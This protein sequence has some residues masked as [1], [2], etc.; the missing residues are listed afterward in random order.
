MNRRGVVA[1]AI[2]V[3]WLGGLGVLVRREFFRP[4]LDR[5]A[6]AALRVQP[7]ATFYAVMQGDRQVGFASSTVDTATMEIEQRDYL[8]ADMLVDGAIRRTEVRTN[9]ITTRMLRLKSFAMEYE[10]NGAPVKVTALVDSDT[11]L[12]LA[13]SRGAG[14]RPDTQRV[15]LAGP[16]LVPT[17][18]PLAVALDERPHVGKSIT[19]PVFD[20]ATLRPRNVRY[21]VR[22]ESL[23]V[24]NDSS[25]FDSTAGRWAPVLPDTIRAW[26]LVSQSGG[27]VDGWV[28]DQGR[29][30]VSSQLGFHLERR[31]YEVAF[32]N[33]QLEDTTR[34]AP[35]PAFT[36][37]SAATPVVHTALSA[38][39]PTI[40]RQ[41]TMR[42]TVIG[43]IAGLDLGGGRQT[44]RGDTVT[45]TREPPYMMTA[46]YAPIRLRWQRNA[47]PNLRTEPG[48]EVDDSAIVAFTRTMVRGNRNPDWIMRQIFV[49]VRDSVQ[50]AP[51]GS[52]PSAMATLRA[53]RGDA[54]GR[55]QLLVA[56]ARAAGVPA[57]M[58][59]GLAFANGRLHHHTWAEVQ[60]RD[61]AAVDPTY[62]Q[63]PASATHL[64]LKIGAVP[65]TSDLQR[66]LADFRFNVLTAR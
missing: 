66:L 30:I 13:V 8:V 49:W 21:D 54:I 36:S 60:L 32:E 27:G 34:R 18:V 63:Y 1:F 55:A 19:F 10:A 11:M 40:P 64:R 4:Q 28:D 46:E 42:V 22:A 50:R 59:T 51:A 20:Q 57:R 26:Q 58:A 15:P 65:G 44:L 14:A 25:V 53:R 9:V 45:V 52:T 41:A 31:P 39:V 38:S 23:F 17:L 62:A 48:I 16:M 43:P 3:A 35:A 7:N 24:V 5:L 33:W 12:T 61:W 6:E 2:L 29:L 47:N 56:L 37:T